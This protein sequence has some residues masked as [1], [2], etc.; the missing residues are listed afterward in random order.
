MSEKDRT[1]ELQHLVEELN[2]KL[3]DSRQEQGVSMMNELTAL[4]RLVPYLILE[5]ETLQKALDNQR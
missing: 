1:H 5:I 2:Q 4:R 3:Q